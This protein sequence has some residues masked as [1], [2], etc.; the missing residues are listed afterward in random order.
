[1][2]KNIPSLEI[3]E[4]VVTRAVDLPRVDPAKLSEAERK[5]PQFGNNFYLLFRQLVGKKRNATS[6]Y[7][8]L[9]RAEALGDS[10]KGF[11]ALNVQLLT[12]L[13]EA[14]LHEQIYGDIL[15]VYRDFYSAKDFDG[16]DAFDAK[17]QPGGIEGIAIP[18]WGRLNSLLAQAA[19]AM[20]QSGIDPK[21][22]YG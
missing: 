10:W 13:E 7:K 15:A 22:F 6:A 19:E 4:E 18:V 3:V 14:L 11:L 21:Q 5:A 9:E 20:T 17:F 12:E 16:G 1:M 2:A 8:Y